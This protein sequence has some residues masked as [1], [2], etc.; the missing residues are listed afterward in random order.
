MKFG[1]MLYCATSLIFGCIML[2]S[3]CKLAISNYKGKLVTNQMLQKRILKI[4]ITLKDTLERQ[5]KMLKTVM[6][7]AHKDPL[8]HDM[9][10]EDVSFKKMTGQSSNYKRFR[11]RAGNDGDLSTF[12]HTGNQRN[13][14]WWVDLG[15][16]FSVHH[17]EIWNRRRNG[18]RLH[19]MTVS[20][21]PTLRRMTRC[22]YY[23]G[24]ARNGSHIILKCRKPIKGRV[25]K[26]ALRTRS[27]FHLAEV[28]VF[29]YKKTCS[30]K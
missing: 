24:P 27:Y 29:A 16:S 8:P 21:G 14:Y 10:L 26:L 28:K 2:S 18:N 7:K 30:P 12:F 20:V 13:P 1:K 23:R 25:V 3:A 17:V 4:E 6:E 5:S 9:C 19:V 22:A 15:S 11:A